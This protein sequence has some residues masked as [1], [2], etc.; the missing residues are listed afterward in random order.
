MIFFILNIIILI[1]VYRNKQPGSLLLNLFASGILV[2]ACYFL[3]S[4]LTEIIP[5]LLLRTYEKTDTYLF[6]ESL[7]SIAL[8][9]ECIKYIFLKFITYDYIE[10]K[11]TR[12]AIT[13]AVSVSIG[14]SVIYYMGLF[15]FDN[16]IHTLELFLIA[17]TQIGLHICL[18][19]IMG[20]FYGKYR[21]TEQRFYEAL[22]TLVPTIVHEYYLYNPTQVFLFI[23]G[24]ITLFLVWIEKEE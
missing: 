8:M 19:T 5:F 22:A 20:Y 18:G 15:I 11:S 7:L 9:M 1:L 16:R 17:L 10:F 12:D 2:V 24:I 13:Y 21:E 6:I 3:A 4:Q 14:F 23:I